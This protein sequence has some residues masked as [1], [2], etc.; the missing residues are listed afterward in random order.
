MRIAAA[1]PLAAAVAVYLASFNVSAYRE[2]RYDSY[3]R[4]LTAHL[5]DRHTGTPGAQQVSIGASWQLEPTINFYLTWLREVERAT[6]RPGSS[7]Y[8]LMPQDSGL[9]SGMNLKVLERTPQGVVLAT[10]PE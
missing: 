8:M 4:D 5:R 2:W 10:G 3:T 6:P 9:V 7:Y 1:I